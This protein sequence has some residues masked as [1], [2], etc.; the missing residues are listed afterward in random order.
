MIE[1]EVKS[2][3]KLE[4]KKYL[5]QK[6]NYS[7]NNLENKLNLFSNDDFLIL[8]CDVFKDTVNNFNFETPVYYNKYL[9]KCIDYLNREEIQNKEYILNKIEKIKKIITKQIKNNNSNTN[10]ALSNKTF[11]LNLNS[12]LNYTITKIKNNK[13]ISID[14]NMNEIYDILNELIFNIKNPIYIEEILNNYPNLIIVKKNN[15]YLFEKVYDKYLN[16]LLNRND[17]YELLYFNKLVLT[18]LKNS[19]NNEEIKVI[20]LNKI[21]KLNSSL[22]ERAINIEKKEK[23]KFFLKELTDFY[24]NPNLSMEK[25]LENLKI[26]YNLK[27]IQQTEKFSIQKPDWKKYKE[28]KK[29]ILTFDDQ[30]SKIYENAISLDHLNNGNYL[31]G[32]YI[33]DVDGYLE[34]KSELQKY[35]YEN[36]M[37]IK[38]YPM[39]PKQFSNQLSLNEGK[40][41]KV[42]AYL[43]E[44]DQKLNVVNFKVERQNVKVK[45]NLRFSDVKKILE[46]PVETKL[47]KKVSEIYNFSKYISTSKED[48]KE[49]HKIKEISKKILYDKEEKEKNKGARMVSIYQMFLNSFISKYCYEKK[50]PY[51]YR[52]NEFN[53]SIELID[54]IK[55]KYKDNLD[56][57]D[58]LSFIYAVY[59]PSSYSTE[60]KSHA[61]LNLEAYGEISKPMRSLASIIN[62]RLINKYLIDG[63]VLNEESKSK[64]I[65]E[66]NR[67]CEHLN[68]KRILYDNYVYE[69]NKILKKS[70]K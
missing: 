65:N 32:F 38:G 11:L 49:Y 10:V 35:I 33:S 45:Y 42:I 7:T 44:I 24:L 12:E 17:D 62:Q 27:K 21:N 53:R 2:E 25:K 60:N 57:Q 8:I 68:S 16:I 46:Y 18:F 13:N 58:I 5:N 6:T 55:L 64:L 9:F 19:N 28:S 47:K 63:L 56:L 59:E 52:N 48:M 20:V 4:L 67:V 3:L 51:L 31:L 69:A 1:R 23:I 54:N 34:E 36:A 22:E 61:G 29:Y 39:L 15:R 41:K 40:R 26:K 43:F 14:L 30:N 70:K 66:L 50:L 37:S